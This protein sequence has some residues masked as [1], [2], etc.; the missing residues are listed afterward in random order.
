MIFLKNNNWNICRGQIAH[1]H[2][3]ITLPGPAVLLMSLCHLHYCVYSQTASLRP[4]QHYRSSTSDTDTVRCRGRAD[5]AQA[6]RELSWQGT[7]DLQDKKCCCCCL[8]SALGFSHVQREWRFKNCKG[9]TV[10]SK[11]LLTQG[12][13]LTWCTS[14]AMAWFQNKNSLKKIILCFFS[15]STLICLL[16]FAIMVLWVND[17]LFYVLRSTLLK[18]YNFKFYTFQVYH[19]YTT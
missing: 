15:D 13:F 12:L 18:R 6:E 11:T 3:F 10:S 16:F 4:E 9:Q 19:H 2:P 5:W 7:G 1:W 14:K 8:K 17:Y